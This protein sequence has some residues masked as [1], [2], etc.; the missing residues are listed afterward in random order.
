MK[1]FFSS[2][3]T[4]LQFVAIFLSLVGIAFGVKSYLHVKEV[5]GEE[6]SAVF[7]NDLV[8]QVIIALAINAA[9]AIFIHLSAVK[10]INTINE[11]MRALT[12]NDL[13]G[14][15]PY[16]ERGDQIGSTARKAKVFQ[17]NAKKL[18][19]LQKERMLAE[20]EAEE[21]KSRT[22][23]KIAFTFESK[24]SEVVEGVSQ[25]AEKL[26]DSSDSLSTI[27]KS[28]G[29]HAR[30]LSNS[31]QKALESVSTVASAS[32]ELTA[33]ISEISSKVKNST[34][35]TGQAAQK[36]DDVKKIFEDLVTSTN[37]IDSVL[38]LINNI[39]EQINL[40]ALNAT[41]EA[42]RAG[43]AGK[44]F[45]VVASEVKNLATQTS[46]ATADVAT[47]INNINNKT[48]ETEVAIKDII[49]IIDNLDEI[50]KTTA[51]V[52]EEQSEVV[53]QIAI[54]TQTASQ[55]TGE[56]RESASMIAESSMEV[57][58]TSSD[59]N[60]V[61]ETLNQHSQKLKE[62]V[63]DFI[64]SIKQTTLKVS[65][66]P[67]YE[68]EHSLVTLLPADKCSRAVELFSEYNIGA[69]PVTSD[70]DVVLGVLSERDIIKKIV[71]QNQNPGDVI[72]G[73][74]MTKDP[75]T[76]LPESDIF[77]AILSTIKGGYR[78]LLIADH[79]KQLQSV[80][81]HR[82]VGN[83]LWDELKKKNHD[84]N[85]KLGDLVKL[86]RSDDL[87]TL[88]SGSTVQNAVD[89]M[90]EGNF[91]AVPVVDNGKLVGIIT[92]RDVIKKALN[93]NIRCSSLMIAD[94][95]TKN[96][97]TVC[98]DRT[99]REIFDSGVFKKYRHLLIVDTESSEHD[100]KSILSLR[101]FV[102]IPY[103][104]II[105][106]EDIPNSSDDAEEIAA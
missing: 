45:A 51:T 49:E 55:N 52:M 99:L 13:D 9:V 16:I 44:G 86:K 19:E 105:K 98:K 62:E 11:V 57:D 53:H 94:I 33:S 15:I 48:Q 82:D 39:S 56:V 25:S 96:P 3:S 21:E 2:L 59:I 65:E 61:N 46:K 17:E 32:E 23:S 12:R 14:D 102:E 68:K 70:E 27:A 50:S 78:H 76:I 22:M 26:H 47:R 30:N 31:S 38:Q 95:M 60:E 91:G 42:A 8:V 18:L 80:L 66:V 79:N 24:I 106:G 93:K 64:Q 74:V 97:D 37:E 81:S 54:N 75:D 35:I 28:G 85:L 92:E 89:M 103:E 10:P 83:L 40:L 34:V 88:N 100:V 84:A 90:I 69:L 43:E 20:K 104:I 72:V 87:K 5:F 1:R 29:E 77:K 73:D 41:I 4:K 36:G 63:I 71:G 101:D 6:A 67:E 7:V 58:A